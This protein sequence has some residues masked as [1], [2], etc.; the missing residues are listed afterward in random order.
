M[1]EQKKIP[2]KFALADRLRSFRYALDGLR[3][4][5]VTQHNAQIHVASTLVVVAIGWWLQLNANDWR[6]LVIAI[7]LVWLA[8]LFNTAIEYLCDLISP[9]FHLA[10]RRA[11]DIAAGAVLVSAIGALVLGA[12]TF[13]PYLV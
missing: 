2:Q 6:W 8:E 12:V 10:V 9:E 5:F 7:V 1:G 11:K 3:F 4:T 13:W